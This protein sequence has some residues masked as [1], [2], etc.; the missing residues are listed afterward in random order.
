LGDVYAQ[1]GDKEGAITQYQAAAEVSPDERL[2]HDSLDAAYKRLGRNDLAA[3]EQE[4]W[5][6]SQAQ[7][8]PGMTPAE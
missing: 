8:S 6:K 3:T 2:V 5:R 4:R 1:Q 7:A